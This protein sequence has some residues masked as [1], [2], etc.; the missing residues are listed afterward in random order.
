M[1][2]AAP[3][4]GQG[5]RLAGAGLA[6]HH[7][8]QGGH[9]PGTQLEPVRPCLAGQSLAHLCRGAKTASGEKPG[10]AW[11]QVRVWR[12]KLAHSDRKCPSTQ[13]TAGAK[14]PGACPWSQVTGQASGRHVLA[15]AGQC[16][17]AGMPTISLNRCH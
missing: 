11:R 6:G 9:T 8:R 10:P 7:H 4:V 13:G 16:T 17:Q 15:L 5:L 3:L 1:A 12:E 14:L 2:R